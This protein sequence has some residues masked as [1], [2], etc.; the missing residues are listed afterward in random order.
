LPFT[1]QRSKPAIRDARVTPFSLMPRL[2]V[3]QIGCK[4][5]DGPLALLLLLS[6]A[7]TFS[8]GGAGLALFPGAAGRTRE[9]IDALKTNDAPKG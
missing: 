8:R 9:E 5:V 2:A 1:L 4:G 6:A 7:Q 3:H